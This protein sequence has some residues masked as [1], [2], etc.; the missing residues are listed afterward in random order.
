MTVNLD[1]PS[2]LVARL[3]NEAQAKGVSLD[4]YLLNAV[5]ER[6]P[7]AE[8]QADE[9]S[10]QEAREAAGRSIRQLRKGNVL[11]PHLTIRDLMEEGHR[12]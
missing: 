9:A 11:G 12:F 7:T 5:L 1:L 10:N 2:D 8:A 6:I 3:T 4:S